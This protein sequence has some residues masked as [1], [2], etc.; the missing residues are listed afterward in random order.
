M[1]VFR[2]PTNG[3]GGF[4]VPVSIDFSVDMINLETGD[5]RYRKRIRIGT[6]GLF[7]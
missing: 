7:T 5:L 6:C 1:T 3:Q 2:L 4:Q